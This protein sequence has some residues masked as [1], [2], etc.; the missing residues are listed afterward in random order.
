MVSLNPGST[1]P[2]DGDTWTSAGVSLTIGAVSGGSFWAEWD[3]NCSALAPAEIVA[4]FTGLDCVV[5]DVRWTVTDWCGT[6]CTKASAFNGGG[7]VDSTANTRSN[8][9]EVL[10]MTATSI[11]L[12][13]VQSFEGAVCG[14]EIR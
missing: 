13:T 2:S 3:G 6:G 9:S 8:S 12:A 4:D 14:L 10:T 7:P 5:S 11:D 1:S